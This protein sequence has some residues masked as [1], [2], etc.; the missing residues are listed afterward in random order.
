MFN[1]SITHRE[2]NKIKKI[3]SK[4]SKKNE[5]SSSSSSDRNSD[6]SLSS[7]S[8][9]YERRQ[10]DEHNET[11]KLYHVVT[12]NIKIKIQCDE[13]IEYKP[14]FDSKFSLSSGTNR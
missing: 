2:L 5:Y 6:S 8:E 4:I 3:H 7:D 13:A 11:N 10:N 14:K 9:I 1:R 12:N